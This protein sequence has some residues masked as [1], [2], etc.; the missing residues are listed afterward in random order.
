M[1]CRE[2]VERASDYLDGALPAAERGHL[3]K[4][5]AGCAGCRTYLEQMRFTVRSLRGLGEQ[6]VAA[7]AKQSLLELFRSHHAEARPTARVIP[8]GIGEEY[9]APGDHI[10]Y[11]WEGEHDFQLGVGFLEAGLRGRDFCVVFGYEEANRKAP[12]VLEKKGFKVPALIEQR[13]LAVLGPSPSG[14]EMLKNIGGVFQR[15]LA[16]GAPALRLLGNIGLGARGLAGRRRHLGLRGPGHGSGARLS[17][18]DRLYVR[19]AR[20]AGTPHPARRFPDASLDPVRA[21][22]LSEPS[23]CGAGALSGE[24][25][26]A[27]RPYPVV[28]VVGRSSLSGFVRMR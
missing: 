10:A 27:L 25:E 19:R 17:L 18:R 15:A 2:T 3:E 12:E 26:A 23:L 16:E 8:L 28:Q 24:P 5:L 4:H 14:D 22:A 1:N 11:F 21:G 20:L 9:A 13:R 7:E 6:P